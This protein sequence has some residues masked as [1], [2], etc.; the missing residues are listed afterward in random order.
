VNFLKTAQGKATAAQ[1]H[2]TP[3]QFL[4]NDILPGSGTNAQK[5]LFIMSF[6]AIM[7]GCLNGAREIVKESAIYRRERTV[8]LGIMPYLFSKIVVLGIF[9]LLQSFILV[10]LVSLK[11][12]YQNSVLLPPF[13][14]IY[15][16]MALTAL[17][18][19]MTGLLISAIVPNNDRAMSIVPLPL[20]P[21][22]IFAG[23]IFS[24]DSPPFL[25][26]LGA[27]FSARW[28]MAA[29]GT[30]VGL[31]G[32]KLDTD[33]FSYVSTIFASVSGNNHTAAV[34]H[35]LLCWGALLL[36]IVLQGIAIAC[37]IKR[38]DQRQ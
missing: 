37:F 8:N 27:F 1:Q 22:V 30:T 24:L 28:S 14:E 2:L 6:A 11:A 7:F 17:A 25:Q 3:D 35:L 13:L 15:V 12:P 29:M 20:I 19:L 36:M 32:D 33:K 4:E 10:A 31:H 9:S 34:E 38:K 5:I 16:T 26:I 18:G 21:Q 23:V